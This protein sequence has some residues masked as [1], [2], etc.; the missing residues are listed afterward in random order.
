MCIGAVGACHDQSASYSA[1]GGTIEWPYY[2]ADAAG[3]K[4][5]PAALVHRGNVQRLRV[6]WAVRAGDL[7]A[8]V[9]DSLL[10]RVNSR[11]K[12][13]LAVDARERA[14]CPICNPAEFRFESTP[15]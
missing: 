8:V 14:P 6:A 5:S 12:G 2:A 3:S 15:L 11:G 7:P 10:H 1:G 9:F 13:A 4:Y